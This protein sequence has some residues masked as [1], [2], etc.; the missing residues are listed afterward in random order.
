MQQQQQPSS[1]V[2]PPPLLSGAPDDPAPFA[3]ELAAREA[4]LGSAHPSVAEAA[5]NLA[6]L[7]NQRGDYA[8]AQPLYERALSIYEAAYGPH[9]QEVAHTLTDLA[10]LHLEQVGAHGTHM[11]VCTLA[12]THTHTHAAC[13]FP[14]W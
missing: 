9:H 10:V 1:V 12:H 2:V 4:A 7:H 3:A 11:A 8:A 14:V 6:I 5:A 13:H